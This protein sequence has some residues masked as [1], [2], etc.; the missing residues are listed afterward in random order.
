[1]NI[2]TGGG[3]GGG[4][5]DWGEQPLG[6]RTK[7]LM[8]DLGTRLECRQRGLVRTGKTLWN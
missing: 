6:L 4:G 2:I 5:K 1:M 3:G 7:P 8:L